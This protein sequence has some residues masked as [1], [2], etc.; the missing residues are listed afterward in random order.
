MKAPA[1][2]QVNGDFVEI[3]ACSLGWL[4]AVSG[5][6]YAGSRSWS[7]EFEMMNNLVGP[8]LAKVPIGG[9]RLV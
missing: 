2:K 5:T 1:L 3:L 4:P 9:E 8:G 6:G 7:L